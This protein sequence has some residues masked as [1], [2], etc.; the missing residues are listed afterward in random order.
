MIT[1]RL[2]RI[3]LVTAVACFFTL[4]AFGNIPTTAST[5]RLLSTACRQWAS[6]II[7]TFNSLGHGRISAHLGPDRSMACDCDGNLSYEFDH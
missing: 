6:G 2:S 5:K 4:V 1:L 3:A 7:L